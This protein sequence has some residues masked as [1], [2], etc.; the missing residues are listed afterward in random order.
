MRRWWCAIAASLMPGYALADDAAVENVGGT[1][2]AMKEHSAIAMVAEYV[3]ARLGADSVRVECVFYLTNTG[4]ATQVSVGFPEMAHGDVLGPSRFAD[5]RSWVDGEEVQVTP[6]DGPADDPIFPQMTW[7][8]KEMAFA[9][10]ATRV[11]R[12]RYVAPPG[13]VVDGSMLFEYILHTGASWAGSIGVADIVV[14][15]DTGA[16]VVRVEPAPLHRSGNQLVWHLRDFEPDTENR[17]VMIQW[18]RA[19]GVNAQR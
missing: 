1:I 4:P 8:V 10:G 14:D 19:A 6:I 11:V 7:W 18:K 5:F 16:E 12:D 3:H 17:V 2:R 13:N 9:A 15:L